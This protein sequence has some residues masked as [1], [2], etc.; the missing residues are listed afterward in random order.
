MLTADKVK[1]MLTTEDIVDLLCKE[2]GSP[3]PIYDAQGNPIFSTC[4]CHGGS[5]FKLY[6]YV[7]TKTFY[8]YSHDGNLGDI[9][10]LVAH[11]KN[12]DDFRES[13]LFVVDYFHL[14]DSE[15]PEETPELTDDWDILQMAEDSKLPEPEPEVD[16]INE[17]MLEYYY[18]LAAPTE[19]IEDHISPEVMRYFGIR[20]DT[21][22]SKIIIPHRDVNGRLIG[23]RGRSYNPFEVMDGKKYMPVLIEKKMYN[24]PLGRNLYGLYENKATISRLKKVL[25]CESEKSV[26]Q[27][28]SYFGI[29]N[30]WCV[31][32]CGSNFST[33]QLQLL[34]NLGIE[35]LIY[36]PDRDYNPDDPE[37]MAQ[38]K[39]KFYHQIEKALPYVN[40][41]CILDEDKLLPLK[42]S[43]TDCGKD[44]LVK[45]L[46]KK[47][48]IPSPN[49]EI[50]E[51]RKK[52]TNR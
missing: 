5:S 41:Y 35:E 39:Q 17:N 51:R 26:L 31:G 2:F 25:V 14:S 40:C 19:W 15:E 13:F 47:I 27:C 28:C 23:I 32:M 11:V 3:E 52:L 1:E 22:L 4:V 44:I 43:P 36:A 38:Y 50:L 37:E 48:Y 20:V 49:A 6:Y 8:C 34:L 24:H 12:Y 46:K 30:S 7:N 29:D 10:S 42:A 21:A 45:L 16:Q 9:F 33:E 18:P